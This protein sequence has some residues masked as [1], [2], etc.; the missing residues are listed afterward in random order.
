MS[1]VPPILAAVD[2]KRSR[3]FVLAVPNLSAV[4]M[5][6]VWHQSV[7]I[8]MEEIDNNYELVTDLKEA[9][10]LVKEA[11]EALNIP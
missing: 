8:P 6:G 10:K 4:C 5:D 9:E 11:R 3:I 7:P 2:K 1:T